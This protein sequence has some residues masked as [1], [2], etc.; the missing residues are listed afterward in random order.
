MQTLVRAKSVKPLHHFIVQVVFENGEVRDID[1]EKYLKGFVFEAIHTNVELFQSVKVEDGALT[2]NIREMIV[3]ID[4]DVLYYDL[5]PASVE[6][7]LV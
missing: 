5:T 2:W 6:K 4:P 1:L 7:E 3:D